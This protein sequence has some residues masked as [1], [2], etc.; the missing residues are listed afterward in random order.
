MIVNNFL[1]LDIEL[2]VL[3]LFGILILLYEIIRGIKIKWQKQKQ[4][5]RR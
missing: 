3:I 5:N 2:K 1:S 4:K